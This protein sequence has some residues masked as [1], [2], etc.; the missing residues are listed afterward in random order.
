MNSAILGTGSYVPDLVLGSAELGARFGV[1]ERWVL[2]RT[3][4]RERRIAAEHE[5]TSD[6]GSRAAERA[7]AAAG[8]RP[9]DVDV[10]I[11]ATAT[12]DKPLPATACLVQANLGAANAVAFDMAAACTGF[13][14][15][16]AVA[17]GMLHTDPM[18]GTALVIGADIYSR[19]VDA[20]DRDTSVLFGDGAGAVVL[21]RT[22]EDRGILASVL[23]TDGTLADLVHIPAGGSRQP[24]TVD[25]VRAGEHTVHMRG[26][27]VR[28]AVAKLLPEL[29]AAVL[30]AADVELTDVAAVVS[31]Q[32]NGVMVAEWA[33]ELGL[34]PG[35]MVETASRYGNTGAASVPI[36]LDHAA[37]HGL[38]RDDIVLLLAFGA[39]VTWGGLVLRW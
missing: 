32:A 27:D 23:G 10:L 35:V 14:Y 13:L 21:G 37:R 7:L 22:E 1:G 18:L 12:P 11:V 28:H 24:S 15:A 4:I 9:K 20:D 33:V 19:V 3:G 2:D 16:M 17:H 38:R 34:R 31:H 39:G 25:T 30:R 29:T 36:T 26:R 8:V 5:A 6:L